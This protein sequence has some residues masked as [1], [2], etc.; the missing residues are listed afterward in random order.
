MT[1]YVLV[2]GASCYGAMFTELKTELMPFGYDVHTPTTHGNLPDAYVAVSLQQSIDSI[3]DY[4]VENDLTD[5]ILAGHSWGGMVITGVAEKAP[6]RIRRLV[7]WNA[8]VP[9]DGESLIDLLPPHMATMFEAIAAETMD[10]SV[11]FPPPILREAFMNCGSA[12]QFAAIKVV[13]Q[14]YATMADKITLSQNP[15]ALE[16]RK[17]YINSTEDTA[18]PHSH[19]WHPRM[20]E[21]LGLFR[22]VQIPGDHM[23]FA[24]DPKGVAKALHM[25]GRD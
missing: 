19:G 23:G 15:A 2:H 3:V 22:L 16:I 11:S 21:K 20:S 14:S 5:V 10:G 8:M 24:T 1:P 7:Y 17:S 4:L 18:L 13:P 25:A 9:N 6:E 12:E